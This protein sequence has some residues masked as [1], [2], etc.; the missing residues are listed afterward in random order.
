ME[1]YE[2]KQIY[3]QTINNAKLLIDRNIYKFLFKLFYYIFLKSDKS[4]R[5]HG[6]KEINRIIDYINHKYIIE[7][8]RKINDK[9]ENKNLLNILKF[10]KTQNHLYAGEIIENIL[11]IIFS[12]AF[13]TK[14][15]NII[16]KYIYNNLKKLKSIKD[17][18]LVEWFIKGKIN[19]KIINIRKLLRN[20]YLK[21]YNFLNTIQEEPLIDLLYEIYSE[22]I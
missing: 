14:K 3:N 17:D 21:I 2:S 8:D 16:E 13:K 15:E 20:D 5:N 9:Y 4:F 19:D 18:E 7:K 10:V 11:I 12:F 6:L 1:N 22:K